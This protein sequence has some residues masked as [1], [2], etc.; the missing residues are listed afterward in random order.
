MKKLTLLLALFMLVLGTASG[1]AP[2]MVNYQAVVRNA[3]GNPVANQSVALRFTVH[4]IN[5]TGTVL[6]QETQTLTTNALGL[7][8][9]QIGAGTP[10]T[11][12]FAA[13]NWNLNNKY[14]EVEA[15]I[16]GGTTYQSLANV[17]LV[18]VPYAL[19]A[20]SSADNRWTLTGSDIYSNNAGGIGIGT[21]AAPNASAMLEIT[22]TNKGILIPRVTQ[23]NRP[24]TPAT[25]LLIYQTDNTPGFYYYNGS[26]WVRMTNTA[27]IGA[28]GSI[29]PYASGVPVTLTTIAGGLVGTTALVGFGNAASGVSLTGGTI[30]LTG[31]GGTLLNF[32]FMSPRSGTISSMSA[33]FSATAAL[34]LVG[35]T[36]TV[37]AQ[38]YTAPA[39][40]NSFSAVP[41]ALVTLSPAYS[42]LVA[43]GAVAYG[44]TSGLSIPVT[45][46]NRYLMVFSA[47]ASG[48]TLI[49]T[50]AGYASAGVNIN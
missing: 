44:T 16:T 48:I 12:T 23:A 42:N 36:L 15:D 26:S 37:T 8:N 50:L 39:G 35:S 34:S 32:A 49:N 21:A 20:G 13:I 46:G 29:L 47:T 28:T 4:D 27:D 17:Q 1:Q 38:L 43:I 30:D 6:Y 25:G 10:V 22:S 33:Q 5:A 2:Q 31:A 3:S 7:V 14:L 45:A 41:G 40:S 24:A 11:G 18:S 19:N 9:I